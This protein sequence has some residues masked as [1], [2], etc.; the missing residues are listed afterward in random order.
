MDRRR[1]VG[2]FVAH[3]GVDF[4]ADAEFGQV[5]PGLDGESDPRDNAAGVVGFKIVEVDTLAVYGVVD[6]VSQAVGEIFPVAVVGDVAAGDFV[7]LP[8]LD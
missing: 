6:T 8:A 4:G 3:E 7:G 5:Y 1:S 2:S